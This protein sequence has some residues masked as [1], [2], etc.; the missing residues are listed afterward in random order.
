MLE[1]ER[2]LKAR[3]QSLEGEVREYL[4]RSGQTLWNVDF[5]SYVIKLVSKSASSVIHNSYSLPIVNRYVC[6][7]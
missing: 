6:A 4:R 1:M 7:S 3:Y 5:C 2:N